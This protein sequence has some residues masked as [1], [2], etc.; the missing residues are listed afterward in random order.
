MDA[1]NVVTLFLKA[2]NDKNLEA[3]LALMHPNFTS[4]LYDEGTVLC[5]GKEE[6]RAIYGKRFRENPSLHISVLSRMLNNEVVVDEHLIRGFDGNKAIR[7]ISLMTIADGLM[8]RADFIRK[9]LKKNTNP[10]KTP[11]KN[12]DGN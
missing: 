7:A 5:R 10:S 6:A 11:I 9:E 1:L 8:I 12:T 3:L 2:Y 4:S